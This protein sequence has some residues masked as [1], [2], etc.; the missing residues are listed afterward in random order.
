MN[1][2]R[3]KVSC[4]VSFRAEINHC[5][6]GSV[7][8]KYFMYPQTPY[9]DF[10]SNANLQSCQY[11]LHEC[12]FCFHIIIPRRRYKKNGTILVFVRINCLDGTSMRNTLLPKIQ[13]YKIFPEV[14]RPT[15]CIKLVAVF[16]FKNMLIYKLLRRRNL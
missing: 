14:S 3:H 15:D 8:V 7:Q 13:G 10:K 12:I 5:T 16:S 1:C 11:L 4:R 9:N 2:K 6:F